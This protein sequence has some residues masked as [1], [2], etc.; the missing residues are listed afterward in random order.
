VMA[1]PL[2]PGY[3]HRQLLETLSRL[4]QYDVFTV[5]VGNDSKSPGMR[6]EIEKMIKTFKL[7]GKIVMPDHC[8]D[9]PAACWLSTAVIAA[10]VLPRGQAMELLD[11]QAIGRPV[12]VTETGTNTELVKGGETAWIVPPDNVDV[13]TQALNEA[14]EMTGSQRIDLAIRTRTFIKDSFPLSKWSTSMAE[15]YALMLGQPHQHERPAA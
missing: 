11:A 5:L 2:A 12:I 15:L 9:W 1:T 14:I 8:T 10:N 13:L 7:E 3:G 4:K 6:L